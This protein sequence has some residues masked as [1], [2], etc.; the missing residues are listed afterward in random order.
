MTATG[1]LFGQLVENVW[2]VHFLGTPTV[3]DL[4]G[5]LAVFQTSYAGIVLPLSNF[6]S[7]NTFTARYLGDPAGPES[8]LFVSGGMA[9][10]GSGPCEPGNVAFCVSLRTAFA[11]RRFRGR[12]YFSGI[13]TSMQV[14]NTV[15]NAFGDAMVAAVQDLISNLATNGTPLAIISNTGLAV[16][17]V[18]AAIATDYYID[19]QR[20]RLTGRGR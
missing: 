16:T 10:G 1:E 2:G 8:T 6:I 20:R 7:Y 18:V 3:T 15:D 4:D 5:I 13:P 9:G 17:D 11:G 12:K 19:S 14:E